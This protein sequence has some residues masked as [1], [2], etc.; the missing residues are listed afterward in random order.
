MT[1]TQNFKIPTEEELRPFVE[2]AIN[3]LGYFTPEALP[4]LTSLTAAAYTNPEAFWQTKPD[5][6]I[7]LK[8]V[9]RR[10]PM[11]A[12]GAVTK[13]AVSEY[14]RADDWSKAQNNREFLPYL[15]VRFCAWCDPVWAGQDILVE[16]KDLSGPPLR[17]C[18]LLIC[19]G[20][21]SQGTKRMLK[22]RAITENRGRL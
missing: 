2:D 7:G 6:V 8:E 22:D 10:D 9:M 1:D 4:L 14:R 13:R 16:V 5:Q 11:G 15:R 18:R 3:H 21:T 17:N 12:L 19:Q 20:F